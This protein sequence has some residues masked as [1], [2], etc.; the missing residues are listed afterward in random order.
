M[1]A[2]CDDPE[3]AVGSR[4]RSCEAILTHARTLP[5]GKHPART[6]P[7]EVRERGVVSIYVDARGA[8]ALEFASEYTVDLNPA[9]VFIDFETPDPEGVAREVCGKCGLSY[10]NAFKEKGWHRATGQ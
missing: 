8:Y 1:C 5:A 7:A 6:L 4:L 10:R 3:R 2:G 9:F